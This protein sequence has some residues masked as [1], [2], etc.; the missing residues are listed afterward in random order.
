ML[1]LAEAAVAQG[2]EVEALRFAALGAVTALPPRDLR[3]PRR[4]VPG[5][6]VTVLRDLLAP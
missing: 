3:P 1:A 2:A 5:L 4:R 6:A